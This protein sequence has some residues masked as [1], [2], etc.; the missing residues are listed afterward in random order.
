M[1][2]T[3]KCPHCQSRARAVKSREMSVVTREVTYQCT[4]AHCGHTYVASL[5]VMRTLSPSA[6][7]NPA[8]TIPMSAHVQRRLLATQLD[9]APVAPG[10]DPDAPAQNLDLFETAAHGP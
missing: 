9:L 10:R 6:T 4:N 3:I 2:V 8:V 1:R 5:E 7:P